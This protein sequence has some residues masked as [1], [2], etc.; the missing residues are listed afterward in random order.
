M[1][2]DMRPSFTGV[3]STQPDE[4]DLANRQGSKAH[5]NRRELG[6]CYSGCIAPGYLLSWA[7]SAMWQF[8]VAG[9][10][11]SDLSFK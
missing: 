9:T 8:V 3:L 5:K 6:T 10:P 7:N 2:E 4:P 1:S 11:G